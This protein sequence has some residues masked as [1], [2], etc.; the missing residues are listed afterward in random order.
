MRISGQKIEP[1]IVELKV[2]TPRAIGPIAAQLT[3]MVVVHA[4]KAELMFHAVRVKSV[5]MRSPAR[6]WFISPMQRS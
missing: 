6:A 5:S 4:P 2:R 1:V 3:V